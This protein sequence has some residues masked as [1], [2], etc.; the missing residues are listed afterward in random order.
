MRLPRLLA[1]FSSG[2]L[3]VAAAT[4]TTI[5]AH[6]DA[7]PSITVAMHALNGSGQDGVAT[8]SEVDGKVVVSVRLD[9]EPA[10]ASEPA[11]VH[12]G[13]CPVI[14]A[15]PA[16]NVGP[17]VGG[18]AS[19]AV[20]LTWADITSGR[21]VLNVHESAEQLGRYVSCGDIASSATPVALPTDSSGGY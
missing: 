8:V 11:H 21:Y 9:G 2:A 10:S 6:A 15:I 20:D 16:Y 5:A 13:R 14:K 7:S 17:V 12:L 19:S 18:K 1:T 4:L 3:A